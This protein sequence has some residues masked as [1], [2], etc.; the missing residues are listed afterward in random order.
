MIPE[1]LIR[2]TPS[3]EKLEKLATKAVC[4]CLYYDLQDTLSE[5]SDEELQA[6]VDGDYDCPICHGEK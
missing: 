1:N 3:R 6:I 4:T 2:K 5:S